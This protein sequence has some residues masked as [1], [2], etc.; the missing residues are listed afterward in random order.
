VGRT[1]S[2]AEGR[3]P[4]AGYGTGARHYRYGHGHGHGYYP[5]YP[6]YGYGYGYGGYYG[7]GWPYYD[8]YLGLGYPYYGVGFG[9]SSGYG[10][11]YDGDGY[12]SRGAE[13]GSV[14]TLVD[15]EKTRVYVDGYYAGLADEFD[16][17]FQHLDV[18]AGR[19][20]LMF[21]LEGYQTHRVKVY[22]PY[23]D[24]LKIHHD[25]VK[26][27]GES[28]EDLVGPGMPG[29]NERDYWSRRREDDAY[30]EPRQYRYERDRAPS[31]EG[32]ELRLS[33]RPDDASVYL[34]G[35]FRGSGRQVSTLFVPPGRHRIE[36]VRP[37]YRTYDREVE[38]TPDRPADVTIELERP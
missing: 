35:E 19:H 11:G 7:Y 23:D 33:V 12:G 20:E 6:Y 28:A 13:P 24:T 10:G 14:R 32:G 17:M 16:G 37:G 2:G 5:Y 29:E 36:V 3:H 1:P 18:S 21:K 8:F 30:A 25:M 15:P 34:D 22:V 31:R 38:V 26:G 4:R 9:Y 27:E